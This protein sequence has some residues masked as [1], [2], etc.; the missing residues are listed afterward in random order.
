MLIFSAK[1]LSLRQP[2]SSQID[3]FG[4]DSPVNYKKAEQIS[5]FYQDMTSERIIQIRLS[6]SQYEYGNDNSILIEGN[7]SN[8][9]NGTLKQLE[10][11]VDSFVPQNM[12]FRK[13]GSLTGVIIVIL[14]SLFTRTLIDRVLIIANPNFPLFGVD[15][16]SIESFALQVML[17]LFVSLIWFYPFLNIWK[18]IMAFYPVVE[19]QIAPNHKLTEKKRREL[20]GNFLVVVFIPIILQIIF[21][22]VTRNIIPNK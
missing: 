6:H 13:Y 19:L 20:F 9:V 16:I 4:D 3:I 14:L 2:A 8:W 17:Y 7:D 22:I 15:N 18:K 1:E 10:E 5:M 12:F 21:E 11:M